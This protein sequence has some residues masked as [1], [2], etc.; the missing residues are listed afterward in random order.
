MSRPGARLRS[1]GNTSDE[2][3]SIGAGPAT[4]MAYTPTTPTGVEAFVTRVVRASAE[5]GTVFPTFC[6]PLDVP[7][8]PVELLEAAPKT[9]RDLV[10]AWTIAA[11]RDGRANGTRPTFVLA[12]SFQGFGSYTYKFEPSRSCY[13]L[14]DIRGNKTNLLDLVFEPVGVSD[15]HKKE[16]TMKRPVKNITTAKLDER[17]GTAKA[18]EK[19]DDDD[20]DK[21]L[22]YKYEKDQPAGAIL[23]SVVNKYLEVY[24]KDNRRVS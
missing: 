13:Y 4:A 23:K 12:T 3:D 22:Y 10:K 24:G 21:E 8:E 7:Y 11:T 20:S 5:G 2:A 17:F 6:S 1:A 18:I 15:K 9:T 16:G 19:G 14:V